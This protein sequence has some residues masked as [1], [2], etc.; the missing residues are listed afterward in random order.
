MLGFVALRK[1][2]VPEKRR[3]CA[4]VGEKVIDAWRGE[5][6]EVAVGAPE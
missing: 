6:E 2:S 5:K 1:L 4:Y 3:M